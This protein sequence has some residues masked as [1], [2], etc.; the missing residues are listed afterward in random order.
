MPSY[1][2]QEEYS[3]VKRKCVAYLIYAPTQMDLENMLNEASQAQVE[4][5]I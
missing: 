2:A 5:S 3:A 4:N 1:I